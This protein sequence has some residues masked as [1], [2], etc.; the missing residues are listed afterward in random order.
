M[1][2]RDTI[3]DK[4]QS[5][6]FQ[7][8][9]ETLKKWS[10]TYVD[11]LI[12][13]D[14]RVATYKGYRIQS[15][16][17]FKLTEQFYK[18]ITANGLPKDT[19]TQLK[20]LQNKTFPDE[21]QFLDEITNEIGKEQTNKYKSVF[22][23]SALSTTDK[24]KKWW[25]RELL[26]ECDDS[27]NPIHENIVILGDPGGGKSTACQRTVWELAKEGLKQKQE[28]A[29]IP[30][31]LELGIYRS[32]QIIFEGLAPYQEILQ[33][34]AQTI[35]KMISFD[36]DDMQ[37]DWQ[38]LQE[39]MGLSPFVFFFDGLNEVGGMHREKLV[40]GIKE[41][42]KFFSGRKHRFVITTRKFDYEYELSEVLPS[43]VFKP[44]EILELDSKGINEFIMLDLGK[45][46]NAYTLLESLPDTYNPDK[47][48]F[49]TSLAV[50]KIDNLNPTKNPLET[51]KD[52]LKKR[53]FTNHQYKQILS[54]LESAQKLLKL[55]RSQEYDRIL[56]LSQNPGTLK[57]IIDVYRDRG[58]IPKSKTLLCEQ[59]LQAR[60]KTQ[61]KKRL[62]NKGNA[63]DFNEEIKF[64]VLQ[65]VAFQM[66]NPNEGLNVT[67]ESI[68]KI[69]IEKGG[70]TQKKAQLLLKELVFSDGFLV[71]K[72]ENWYS[73]I[74]QPYQ[75]YFVARELRDRWRSIKNE[76]KDPLED[77]RMQNYLTKPLYFQ[78]TSGM[79]GLLEGNEVKELITYLKKRK[80]TQR[81]AAL[82]VRNAEDLDPNCVNEFITST[83]QKILKFTLF[84]EQVANI[85]ISFLTL[86]IFAVAWNVNFTYELNNLFISISEMTANWSERSLQMIIGV[87][88]SSLSIIIWFL[89]RKTDVSK[90]W[91]G[92][93]S[94]IVAFV[95]LLFL[96][97][98][99]FGNPNSNSGIIISL[100]AIFF[101]FAL[102]VRLI[103]STIV[104]LANRI[105]INFEEYIVNH[106]LI[107][108]LEILRDM[109]P[110]AAST[111]LEI[112]K[113]LSKNSYVSERIKDA[114]ERTWAESPRTVLEVI[115]Y[116]SVP[117]RQA[118][119]VKV[120]GTTIFRTDIDKSMKE[121]AADAL[122]LIIK[123]SN[124][125]GAIL[126]AIEYIERLA[127]DD[128]I[129]F[130]QVVDL[131]KEILKDPAYRVSI[132]RKAW[133][134]LH[135]LGQ[136]EKWPYPTLKEIF[137]NW[138]KPI[139]VL[140][141][142]LIF[143]VITLLF[144][145]KREPNEDK[146]YFKLTEQSY[147]N[148]K[149][150]SVPEDTINKLK[151]MQ[152]QTFTNE[153]IFLD[154]IEKEIGDDQTEKYKSAILKS[155]E[156]KHTLLLQ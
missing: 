60:L 156:D 131:L 25:F 89:L 129:Y 10:E 130:N 44:L 58:E 45:I 77:R 29:I 118:E 67:G 11:L 5:S 39:C 68:I 9:E 111:I 37:F 103:Y 115:N 73:F 62:Y 134:G 72:D 57:D 16:T 3:W 43:H 152:D 20:K 139:L 127:C 82:C 98:N 105:N 42:T 36:I 120:I 96:S 22:L 121:K 125:I 146:A 48:L 136:S 71:E 63:S 56:W 12:T 81:L 47:T 30:V 21:K 1:N 53:E 135:N 59:A 65:A 141:I 74:K 33:L 70:L 31:Y 137:R 113:E 145:A 94:L 97:I 107:Y 52:I 153:K 155:A 28:M 19:I 114:I 34:C 18:K 86:A 140:S 87:I 91:V 15:T 46:T 110:N 150:N 49:K 61:S 85:I 41:F 54:N 88:V 148:L 75:E 2:S 23:E 99:I 8:L 92:M 13:T 78:V 80:P 109:G 17:F 151:K 126:G 117:A 149:A 7:K 40:L 93:D 133:R 6:Y 95:L 79:T 101:F 50:L 66:I 102:V 119:V 122:F 143:L 128:P 132:R 4:I 154:A 26:K 116:V 124:R 144:V 76:G 24:T 108:Y 64:C 32:N 14:I 147:I 138:W 123:Q 69:F 112:Q 106:R 100:F 55:L 83:R 35:S 104:P 142:L 38:R 84:P 90:E 27:G 51:I